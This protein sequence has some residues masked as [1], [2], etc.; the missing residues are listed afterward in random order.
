M[1]DKF[2]YAFLD[3]LDRSTSWIDKLFLNKPKKKKKK[4]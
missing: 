3:F 4:K 2:I 1:L